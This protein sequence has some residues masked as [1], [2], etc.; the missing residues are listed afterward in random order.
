MTGCIRLLLSDCLTH[1]TEDWTTFERNI[2]IYIYIYIY[3]L[4]YY[5]PAFMVNR[6]KKKA[7]N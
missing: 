5:L 7:G 4:T 6:K 1:T 2:Y 3:I